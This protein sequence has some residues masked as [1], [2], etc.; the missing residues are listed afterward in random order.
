[1]EQL[2]D[3]IKL[4]DEELERSNQLSTGTS[5][6][7]ALKLVNKIKSE[8]KLMLLLTKYLI[9]KLSNDYNLNIL[10]KS[11]LYLKTLF[12]IFSVKKYVCLL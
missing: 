9:I 6:E 8:K 11:L 12:K 4:C 7:G 3:K 10:L 2:L 1:M 5:I